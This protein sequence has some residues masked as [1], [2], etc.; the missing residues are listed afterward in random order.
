VIRLPEQPLQCNELN[1]LQDFPATLCKSARERGAL[2]LPDC[3]V[4]ESPR[5]FTGKA[6][7]SALSSWRLT[8]SG[9]A[10]ANQSQEV[11]EPLIDGVS[12]EGGD[13]HQVPLCLRG[14]S[15]RIRH[16]NPR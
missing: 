4:S 12:V 9:S 1:D 16:G 3:F 5:A 15:Q 14:E 2:T 7:C 11:V 8:T 6:P 13:F 10:F